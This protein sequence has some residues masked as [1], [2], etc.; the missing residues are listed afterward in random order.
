[1]KEIFELE[2]L[3]KKFI[4]EIGDLVAQ[5]N[6]ACFLTLGGTKILATASVSD[7]EKEELDFFP[8]TVDYEE[9]YYAA[10]KIKGPRYI[11]RETRPSDEAICNARMIDRAIRP[12][13][14]EDL[15]RE[16]QVVVTVLSWDGENDPDVLGLLGS[17]IALSISDIP[18]KGPV[19]CLRVGKIGK[20]FIFNPTYSQKESSEM[21]VV[22]AGVKRNGKI[23]LNMIEGGFLESK[24][25]E[26]VASFDF[27][28]S[29]LE[30]LIEFQKKIQ[31]KIGKP[32]I[33]VFPE[34]DELLQEEILKN[35]EKKFEEALFPKD[36]I[37]RGKFLKEVME[38]L[39]EFLKLNFPQKINLGFKIARKIYKKILEKNILEKGVRPDGRGLDEMRN[40]EMEVGVLPRT[41]GSAIFSRG[42][43]KSLSIVTLGAPDDVQLLE[44]MEISGKKRFMH[45]YNFPPYSAGEIK[46]IK[47]PGRREIGHG[48]LVEKALSPIIP[49]FDEFPYTIRIVSEI[50]SSNGSTSMA[51]SSSS[52]LALMDAGVPI[53][54]PVAGISLGLVKEKILVD[55][56]GP[57]DAFGEMDF[58]VA[59]T[60][61]GITAIQMDVKIDGITREILKECLEKGKRARLKILEKMKE[62]L[63]EPR[64]EVSPLAPKVLKIKIDP[65]KIREVIGP[66]GR[67]IN[68]IIAECGVSIKIEETGEIY[69]T[70]EKEEAPK[71]AAVWIKNITRQIRIGEIFYGKV[72]RILSFGAIIEISPGQEGLLHVSKMKKRKI[73]LLKI[74]EIIPVKVIAIDEMGRLNLDLLEK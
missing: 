68:E 54:R 49:S 42:L 60:E 37:E 39:N 38:E 63:P 31:E 74:G 24:E 64:R 30:K 1:M 55:I 3:N 17:S 7:Y 33:Q 66:G 21:D 71:K 5:A 8:L 65:E 19:G 13:F 11:K 6:G 67:V 56:Q 45:H 62:I 25:E 9:R 46:P 36:K 40:I 26:V 41:H 20:D 57:E 4:V 59:G 70:A 44:G 14:P 12:L 23:L 16:V 69:I 61:K 34:K 28:L 58:K 32:K 72:K 43:T 73:K 51:A 50:L 15:K 10:G 27:S 22:F 29:I 53:K 2:I 47:G 52:S 35:F 48:M 18:W